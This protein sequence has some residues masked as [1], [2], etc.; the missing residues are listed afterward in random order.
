MTLTEVHHTQVKEDRD[1]LVPAIDH[2]A[3]HRSFRAKLA[4]H[5]LPSIAG[6]RAL[7]QGILGAAEFDGPQHLLLDFEPER[8]NKLVKLDESDRKRLQEQLKTRNASLKVITRRVIHYPKDED[9]DGEY[10]DENRP[11]AWK[12]HLEELRRLEMERLD[13]EEEEDVKM[14]GSSR[15]L[16]FWVGTL[17]IRR[18]L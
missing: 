11:D 1:T 6:N 12:A 15:S 7:I 8:V 17:A 3:Y 18:G 2:P 16:G 14:T 10:D 5:N 4:S 9:D 13:S